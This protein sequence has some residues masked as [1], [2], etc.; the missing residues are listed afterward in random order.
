M[1]TVRVIVT[2]HGQGIIVTNAQEDR[3]K[4]LLF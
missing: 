4:F 3:G 2:K 1:R